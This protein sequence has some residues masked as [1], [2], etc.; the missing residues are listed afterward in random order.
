MRSYSSLEAWQRSEGFTGVGG[1]NG[2]GLGPSGAYGGS[3]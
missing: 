2:G 1:E 3:K